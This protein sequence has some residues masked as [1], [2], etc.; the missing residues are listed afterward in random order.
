M[1]K[2]IR[3]SDEMV[4]F[5]REH[6]KG[7]TTQEL[8]DMINEKFSTQL[9]KERVTFAKERYKVKSYSKAGEYRQ[10]F[11]DEIREFIKESHKG[12]SVQELTNIVNKTFQTDFTKVQIKNHLYDHGMTTGRD[13]RFKKGKEHFMFKPI[14]SEMVDYAG[15]T[16]VKVT[17][18]K[19]RLKSHLVWEEANGP[20]PDG[21]LLIYLDKNV[22]N[23]QL[24]NLELVDHKE[25]IVL[26]HLPLTEN[27]ELNRSIVTTGRLWKAI[28]ERR[29]K[30]ND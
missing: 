15:R 16:Y 17:D 2:R 25:K 27:K 19:W 28:K 6:A 12:N 30:L 4:R 5:L 18:T 7:R 22:G 3:W 29:E 10:I 13:T 14:G 26:T 9:D 11:T 20:M 23:Y 1:R 21:H 24:D 8:A